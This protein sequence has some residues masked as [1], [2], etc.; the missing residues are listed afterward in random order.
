[1]SWEYDPAHW[2]PKEEPDAADLAEYRLD[3]ESLVA[4]KLGNVTIEQALEGLEIMGY[5]VDLMDEESLRAAI[6]FLTIDV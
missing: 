1:M 3:F 2:N 4:E 6:A 5:E